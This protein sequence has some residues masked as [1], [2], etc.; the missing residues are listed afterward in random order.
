VALD[1][2]DKHEIMWFVILGI[3]ALF[4]GAA[5]AFSVWL[6]CLRMW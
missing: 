5:V 6:I 3:L 4:V 2:G 1:R